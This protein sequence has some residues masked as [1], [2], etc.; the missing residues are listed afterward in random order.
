MGIVLLGSI[1]QPRPLRWMHHLSPVLQVGL[2]KADRQRRQPGGGY[3]NGNGCCWSCS[4]QLN[5]Q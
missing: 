3:S 4:A 2:A 5:C 1:S